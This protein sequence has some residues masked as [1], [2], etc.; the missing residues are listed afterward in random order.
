MPSESVL[1]K[2][3]PLPAISPLKTITYF[4]K[5]LLP[6][7]INHPLFSIFLAGQVA[8]RR[9]IQATNSLLHACRHGTLFSQNKAADTA[10]PSYTLMQARHLAYFNPEDSAQKPYLVSPM[11]CAI[12]TR[13]LAWQGCETF[14]KRPVFY[15]R[16]KPDGYAC[17]YQ[18]T[19]CSLC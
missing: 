11:P 6:Y 5:A 18:K 17:H 8:F 7:V 10:H 15:F 14:I 9:F 12:E 13:R 3:S 4:G 19:A 16:S 1:A 2:S